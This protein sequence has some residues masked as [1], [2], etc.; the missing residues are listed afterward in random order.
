M[1]KATTDLLIHFHEYVSPEEYH[2][3]KLLGFFH[4][5]EKRLLPL[6]VWVSHTNDFRLR[7]F[8]S[9]L[10]P[11]EISNTFILANY[12]PKS[13]YSRVRPDFELPLK[14]VYVGAVSMSTM[15]TKEF[16]NWVIEQQGK[17]IWD[18]YAYNIT[19]E[20][21]MYL[22]NVD[23]KNI[24][25]MRGVDYNELPDILRR[26]QIGVILYKG[27]IPNYVYNAPNKLFEYLV[28]GLAVWFPSDMLAT[29]QYVTN[30][31]YPEVVKIDFS[32]LSDLKVDTVLDR[33]GFKA[34]ESE[35]YCELEL[36]PLINKLS[37]L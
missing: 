8:K 7:K 17:V 24:R 28:C 9:D 32:R 23:S 25:F 2:S 6:A 26:Y 3:Q 10:S 27:F 15:Y 33:K 20:A 31:T 13:W 22:N 34:K 21:K 5:L 19:D 18:I 35:F 36:K 16:A 29:Y 14:I 30:G 4:R 11:L 12:P 1:F 37:M